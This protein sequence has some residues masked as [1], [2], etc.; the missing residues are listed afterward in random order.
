MKE[1]GNKVS[2]ISELLKKSGYSD[3]AI[4][5]Y[6]RKVKV[7]EIKDPSARSAYTGPCG[8]T[9]EVFLRIA[10]NIIEDAKFMAIG[11]AGAFASGSALMEMIKGKT[12]EDAEKINEEDIM[13]HLEKIPKQKIHC[14]CLAKRTLRQA[15]AQYKKEKGE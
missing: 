13:N 11:C 12:L 9:M 15:I 8:D 7:G 5:Y 10:S 1:S 2:K 3:K 14:A 4:E 6:T